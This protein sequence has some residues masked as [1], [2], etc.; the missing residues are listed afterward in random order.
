MTNLVVPAAVGREGAPV[1]SKEWAERTRLHLISEVSDIGHGARDVGY[2]I[3]AIVEH[4]AWEHLNK[5]DGTTFA[6]AE[7]FC[8]H[9]RPW[10]LGMP[11][12]ELNKHLQLVRQ[13]AKFKALFPPS[14][15]PV[16]RLPLDQIRTDGGTQIREA[17]N[18]ATA[19][20]YREAMASGAAFP[21]VTVFY[22]GEAFWLADGFH[23]LAATRRLGLSDILAEVRPGTRRDAILH[24]VGA[25]NEH[26][27]PRTNADKRRAV[28]TL[29]RDEEWVK[30][31]D[32]DLAKLA[33]VSS[34]FVGVVRRELE[35]AGDIHPMNVRQGANGKTRDTSKFGR[36]KSTEG[37]AT[38]DA[39]VTYTSVASRLAEKIPTARTLDETNALLREV[40]KALVSPTDREHLRQQIELR[41]GKILSAPKNESADGHTPASALNANEGAST[42]EPDPT[43]QTTTA[44]PE[45]P[46]A[47]QPMPPAPQ[48][49]RGHDD[50]GPR[51]AAQAPTEAPMPAARKAD[52]PTPSEVMRRIFFFYDEPSLPVRLL[53]RVRESLAAWADDPTPAGLQA[54]LDDLTN[55]A[56]SVGV[57]L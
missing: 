47:P 42:E 1:G 21:P 50:L 27:L 19:E 36:K 51:M 55:E 24:S 6:S 12:A 31:Y 40:G 28:L 33:H 32:T 5:P 39:T 25:N 14:A 38:P 13:G 44:S 22:D 18:E 35:E 43:H 26:G 54:I 10:G 45:K 11:P 8:C 52:G 57:R 53:A 30:S 16:E 2:T 17:M 49:S 20:A 23:R 34:N 29:L 56:G 15:H 4:R 46:A 9:P 41:Q 7:E 3:D 37:H 48:P